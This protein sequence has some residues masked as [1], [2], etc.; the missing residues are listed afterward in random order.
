MPT[1]YKKPAE[2]GGQRKGRRAKNKAGGIAAANQDDGDGQFN[3]GPD[4]RDFQLA[5]PDSQATVPQ[6]QS[7]TPGL[8]YALPKLQAQVQTPQSGKGAEPEP[9]LSRSSPVVDESGFSPLFALPG[10]QQKQQQPPATTQG[11]PSNFG[12]SDPFFDPSVP[13]SMTLGGGSAIGKT[14]LAM[15][16]TAEQPQERQEQVINEQ[17][18]QSLNQSDNVGGFQQMGNWNDVGSMAGLGVSP[19]AQTAQTNNQNGTNTDGNKRYIK[20][21]FVDDP[22][23]YLGDPNLQVNYSEG[24]RKWRVETTMPI[25]HDLGSDY[26]I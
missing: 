10:P 12:P 24:H 17:V 3:T 1:P 16:A 22:R 25:D 23:P 14:N 26:D 4:T 7:G 6:I 5:V 2:A 8:Q 9:Q 21:K 11:G 20:F 15:T 19:V 18:M 13:L